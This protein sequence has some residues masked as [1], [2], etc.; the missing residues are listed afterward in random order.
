[1]QADIETH[2][3]CTQMS[4][5]A[6]TGSLVH[7]KQCSSAELYLLLTRVSLAQSLSLHI[8]RKHPRHDR[9]LSSW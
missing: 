6:D 2:S 9:Q 8:N 1:M 7:A 3:D 4:V 5:H